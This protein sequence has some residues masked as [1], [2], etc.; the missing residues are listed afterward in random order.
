MDK[1]KRRLTNISFEK[2][3]CHVALVHKDQGGAA[4]GY[5]TLVLKATDD[6]EDSAVT[7]QLEAVEKAKY[8]QE[9]RSTLE[10]TLRDH[11][12]ESLE[13]NWLYL[14]DFNDTQVVFS[15]DGKIY[16]AGYSLGE[17]D[18]YVFD[19][20]AKEVDIKRVYELTPD[21]EILLSED[22]LKEVESGI[23]ELLTK[24][25]ENTDT[26]NRASTLLKSTLEKEKTKMD[27]IQKAV[28]EAEKVL[29]AQI[30]EMQ[31]KLE[32][33]ATAEKESKLALRKSA[34][35]EVVAE[36]QIEG[37]LKNA[38]ALSE[39]AFAAIVATMKSLKAPVVDQDLMVQKSGEG[40]VVAPE[41]TT[42]AILK[43]RFPQAQ[44]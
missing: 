10:E 33:Y 34:L 1:A 27:E 13:Y 21:G 35:A 36:D 3:G 43:A 40:D 9:L 17:N 11:F 25:L 12:E 4:N 19:P 39:E 18:K 41:Q 44:A 23:R 37:I 32:A 6:I 28:A 24:S 8:Y 26:V 7:E 20:V 16:T 31:S 15:T 38:E 5:T 30:E 2:E 29:K 22:A 14:E 42:A